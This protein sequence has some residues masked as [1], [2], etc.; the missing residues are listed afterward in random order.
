MFLHVAEARHLKSY[1][2]E[3]TFSDGRRGVADLAEALVGPVFEPLRDPNLFA[4]LRVD[5]E[6]ETIVWP[7]GAD[8]APEYLYYLAFRHEPQLQQRFQAWGYLGPRAQT[9]L[10]S[11]ERSP[12]R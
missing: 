11:S 5:Q 1:E 12:G 2:V 7:N 9:D 6:L 8:L 3:L 4:Q 10:A